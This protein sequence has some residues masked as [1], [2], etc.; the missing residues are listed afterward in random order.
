MN[1]HTKLAIF[2][3]PILTI[4]GYILSDSYVENQATKKRI[5]TLTPQ[6]T[7]DVLAKKCILTAGDL[8]VNVYD[9]NGNTTINSTFP[10]DAATIFLIDRHEQATSY[11]LKK[12]KSAYYW[13]QHTPLRIQL[14]EN[15]KQ[16]IRIVAQIKGGQ[17][18]SEFYT[19]KL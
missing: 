17:Y 6:N 3:A 11:P 5:F 10:L 12:D 4:A 8:K 15:N 16:K 1:K 9:E 13:S 18:I 7:C 19:A 2:I 14:A